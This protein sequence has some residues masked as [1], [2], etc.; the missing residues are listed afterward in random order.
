VTFQ[1]R[2][3]AA[4]AGQ[5]EQLILQGRR[6]PDRMAATAV[7][8]R[9]SD[10]RATRDRV[11]DRAY[12]RRFHARHIGQRNDPPARITR[13]RDTMSK[14]MSHAAYCIGARCD[15]TALLLEHVGERKIAGPHDGDHFE[16]SL[17]EIPRC[18]RGDCDTVGKRV[19]E[20][21]TAKARACACS[22]EDGDDRLLCSV[23]A[24]VI[25]ASAIS[26]LCAVDNAPEP[27]V[28]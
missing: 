9:R 3:R 15:T 2:A 14:A 24:R 12:R 7:V 11:R 21:P 8:N 27:S 1:D 16:L 19:K 6:E 22:E 4:V 13:R 28:T 23:H 5:R 17:K 18:M 10:Q 25:I 20:L 26:A